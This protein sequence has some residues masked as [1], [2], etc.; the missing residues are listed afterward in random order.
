MAGMLT[1]AC[2]FGMTS[3]SID[4]CHDQ[5]KALYLPF[6]QPLRSLSGAIYLTLLCGRIGECS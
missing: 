6:R 3:C 2:L 1:R 4:T 5:I